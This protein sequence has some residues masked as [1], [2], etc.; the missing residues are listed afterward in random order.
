MC[1]NQGVL[2][3][4]IFWPTLKFA[5]KNFLLPSDRFSLLQKTGPLKIL[6]QIKW[7]KKSIFPPNCPE[8]WLKTLFLRKNEYPSR[9]K[10]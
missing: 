9:R 5:T 4:A 6:Q 10:F 3:V 2:L 8:K 7:S 1:K